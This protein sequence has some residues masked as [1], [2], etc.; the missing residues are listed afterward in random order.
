MDRKPQIT[1][2]GTGISRAVL[3]RWLA[4]A[5]VFGR[6]GALRAAQAESVTLDVM[7]IHASNEQA[8]MDRRLE[9][10]EYQLRRMFKFEYYKHYGEASAVVNLPGETTLDLGHGMKLIVKASGS[11]GKIRAE[12]NWKKGDTSALNTTVALKRGQHVILGGVPHE[13]GTL[14]MTVVAR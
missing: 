12:V 6:G 2:V 9:K 4:G 11:D 14:I 7:L 13:G 8:P 3:L 1:G 10:V 5:F